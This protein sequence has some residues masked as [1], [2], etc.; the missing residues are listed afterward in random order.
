V[1]GHQ[2]FARQFLCE[3][4][5]LAAYLMAATGDV[6]AME[7]LLQSVAR[8]LWEKLAEYDE[9]RPFG[10]W[11]TGV[12]QLEVL[13]WR[14]QAARSREVLSEDSMRLL[15]ETAAEQGEELSQRYDYL[16]ECLKALG[17]SARGVLQLKYAQ[18]CRIRE[19]A[20]QLKKS[21]PAVEMLLVRSRRSL[22]SCIE[23]KMSRAQ[24][25]VS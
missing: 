15:S 24:G 7:D 3:Q 16:A 20:Q 12:A 5:R 25:G 11:A 18:G 1:L 2:D 9:A 10:A 8:I 22:R 4:R 17:A 19:I 21:T 6:H 23:R 14:Q 13:K